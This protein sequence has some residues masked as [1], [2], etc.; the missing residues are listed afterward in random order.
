MFDMDSESAL[1]ELSTQICAMT[2]FD[3][4]FTEFTLKD[5]ITK[6][7]IRMEDFQEKTRF[8]WAHHTQVKPSLP[9]AQ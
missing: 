7:Y 8:F 3:R 6:G 9:L 4:D 1:K 2:G 5:L